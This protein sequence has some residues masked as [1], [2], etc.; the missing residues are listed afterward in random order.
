[1]AEK[2]DYYEV[3]GVEKNA[4][5]DEIKKAYRKAAIK[6]HP[7]KNPGDKEAE[8]KFKEAA[9]AYDVLSNPDK[10]ARY[11]QFGHAG[12]DPNFGAGGFGGFGGGGFDFGDIF[13]SFFGGGGAS[14]ARRQNMPIEGDDVFTRITLSFEEA[15]FGCKKDIT[16]NRV[17]ACGDCEGSGA[18]KGSKVDTCAQCHGTGRVTVQQRTMLGMMQTQQT[19]SACRGKGKIIRTPCNS[20]KGKGKVRRRNT[21]K[22]NIPGGVDEGTTMRVRG[23]GSVGVNGGPTGDLLVE[24]SIKRH[25]IFTREDFDV[26]CE[27]PITF[28]QAALGAEIE[29]PTLD[30]KVKFD[31][32]EGMENVIVMDGDKE[33]PTQITFDGKVIFAMGQVPPMGYKTFTVKEGLGDKV[34]ITEQ[35]TVGGTVWCKIGTGWISMDYVALD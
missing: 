11:D 31:L 5:A 17:E 23:G 21:V 26:L 13:S 7:D 2:R 16:F 28:T 27:V 15:V 12:V 19:C 25:A 20:C 32:P 22:V 34:T 3:L 30:G 1:M 33:L 4:N 6:Y 24:I 8:E 18:Q 9:E 14:S 10:R 29:V 35:K